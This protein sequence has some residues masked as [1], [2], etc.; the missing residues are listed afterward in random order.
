[1]LTQTI[2]GSF[3]LNDD[4]VV[5]QPIEKRGCDNGLAKDLSPLRE[6]AI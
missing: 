6:A 1:M 3:D 5:K 2:A 4:S